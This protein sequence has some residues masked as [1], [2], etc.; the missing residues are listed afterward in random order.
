MRALERLL[1]DYKRK[2]QTIREIIADD[3]VT[4]ETLKRLKVK[5][6]MIN[7]FIVDI[8]AA[9]TDDASASTCNLH[10]VSNNEVA[11]CPKCQN[12]RIKTDYGYICLENE[13]DPP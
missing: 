9:M 12:E 11:V 5:Q 1:E 4:E 7:S 6:G 10:I 2:Q 13:C 3:D 8:H